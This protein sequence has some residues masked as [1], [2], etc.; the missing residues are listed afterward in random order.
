MSKNLRP[1][2]PDFNVQMY[3]VIDRVDLSIRETHPTREVID[4][5]QESVNYYGGITFVFDN[6]EKIIYCWVSRY[7][8]K[9]DWAKKIAKAINPKK[10]A[11][12]VIGHLQEELGRSL[13]GYKVKREVEGEHSDPFE[14]MFLYEVQDFKLYQKHY[15]RDDV[16]MLM[17][18]ES[19][20]FVAETTTK[21]PKCNW[22]IS[23]GKSKCPMCQYELQA[24]DAEK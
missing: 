17:P 3:N 12:L 9:R 21:C 7:A 2:K 4:L 13:E 6:I 8:K 20:Y 19:S 10:N 1:Y 11:Q 16:Q 23:A 22:I 5:Y 18:D 15:Y 24:S 14:T